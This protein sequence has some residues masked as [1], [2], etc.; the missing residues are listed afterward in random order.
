MKKEMK[1]LFQ[2]LMEEAKDGY[3]QIPGFFFHLCFSLNE[4]N[5][6]DSKSNNIL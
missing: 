2:K 6:N 1:M 3:H 4:K 5:F